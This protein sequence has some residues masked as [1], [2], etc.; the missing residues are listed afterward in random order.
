MTCWASIEVMNISKNSLEVHD[1]EDLTN[2]RP[3]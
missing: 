3:T 1:N 2:I